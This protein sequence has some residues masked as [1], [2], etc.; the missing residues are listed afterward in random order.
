MH[1]ITVDDRQR[2]QKLEGS[3]ALTEA[4][5]VS[6]QKLPREAGRGAEGYFDPQTG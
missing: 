4:A 6:L 1:T 5:A 3:A 2:F